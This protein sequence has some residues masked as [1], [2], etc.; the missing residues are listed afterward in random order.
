MTRALR[1]VLVFAAGFFILAAILVLTIPYLVNVDKYRDQI[2]TRAGAA[3]GRKIAVE[4]IRLSVFPLALR[5]EKVA[6]GEDPA[7]GA[8]D[9]ATVDH[10]LVRVGLSGLLGGNIEVGMV[11]ALGP[12]VTLIKNAAGVWNIDSLAGRRTTPGTTTPVKAAAGAAVSSTQLDI[13]K[14]RLTDGFITIED[15]SKPKPSTQNF[16]HLEL[17]LENLAQGQPFN[18]VLSL[19]ADKGTLEGSGTAGPYK[20]GPPPSL[21]VQAHI[22]M[23]DFEIAALVPPPETEQGLLSGAID[24]Q[25]DGVNATVDGNAKIEKLQTSPKGHPADLPVTADFK[26]AY[27]PNTEI[28]TLKS[29]VVKVGTA[30]AQITGMINRKDAAANRVTVH[31]D[32]ASLAELGKVLPALG[33]VLPSSAAFTSGTLTSA[34]DLHGAFV[35]LSGQSS[36]HVQ[37][38]KLKGFSITQRIATVAKFAGIPGGPDTDIERLKVNVTFVNGAATFSGIELVVPGI[39]VTGAGTMSA[40]DQLDLRLNAALTG[41]AQAQVVQVLVGGKGVPILVRGTLQNPEFIPDIGNIAR[42]EISS[43]VGGALGGNLGQALG[44]LLSGKKKK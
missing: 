7:F 8:G 34:A 36:I 38:A 4:R 22:K 17:T 44:G 43:R 37:N 23:T 18:F 26:A 28:V 1:V 11:E 40:S 20:P 5:A 33:V 3:T 41:G 6:V 25:S 35:P 42:Q 31:V 32:G 10:M 21:P 12:H 15:R 19:K 2:V 13:A 39:T 27:A 30:Q 29:V 16:D 14:L 9:F 24:I